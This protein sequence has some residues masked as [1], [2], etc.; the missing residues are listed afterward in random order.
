MK[1]INQ[2]IISAKGDIENYM[3]GILFR[4]KQKSST[5]QL[6]N[7]GNPH[8]IY[9]KK[10]EAEP[11]ILQPKEGAV[12]GGVI[13]ISEIHTVFSDVSV[14]VDDGDVLIYYTDGISEAENANEEQFKTSG[15]IEGIN[16]NI[17]GDASDILARIM[18][19][20]NEFRGT[21]P[22]EDDITIVVMKKRPHKEDFIEVLEEI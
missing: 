13:G 1:D 11:M 18:S 6:V 4:Y 9:Y 8:P 7:A 16:G 15:I 12:R 3:T 5:L 10:D 21:T 14:K 22:L 19:H 20:F 17:S 2:N